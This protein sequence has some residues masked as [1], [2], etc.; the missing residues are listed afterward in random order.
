[1]SNI[2]HCSTINIFGEKTSSKVYSDDLPL[3]LAAIVRSEDIGMS[4]EIS[5]STL[6]SPEI[7][8]LRTDQAKR[9]AMFGRITAFV[10]SQI[11]EYLNNRLPGPGSQLVTIWFLIP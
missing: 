8:Q 3:L 7:S 2:I 1:M 9:T 5:D 4:S 11:D 10:R 6:D